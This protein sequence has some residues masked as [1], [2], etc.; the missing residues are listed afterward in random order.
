MYIDLRENISAT[1]CERKLGKYEHFFVPAIHVVITGIFIL[2]YIFLCQRL[3]G[4]KF[5]ECRDEI[6]H[7]GVEWGSCLVTLGETRSSTSVVF[8]LDIYF[9]INQYI[10]VF[11][12]LAQVSCDIQAPKASKPNEG[13]LYVHVE[14][15]PMGA[16]HFDSNKQSDISTQVNRLLEKCLKE[17]K[18]VDL[19]ALCIVADEKVRSNSR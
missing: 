15:S 17:S 1:S 13:L 19:E 18:C 8:T 11:R 3:D 5:N 14:M 16:L 6:I 2:K 9:G 7:F 10:S 4:R 12:V